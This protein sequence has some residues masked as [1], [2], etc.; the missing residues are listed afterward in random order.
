MSQSTSVAFVVGSGRSGTTAL[1]Q[2]LCADLDVSFISS[3][4]GS[5]PRLAVP[6]A[7]A[8]RVTDRRGFGPSNESVELLDRFGLGH[9][10]VRR[11][12]RALN[13]SDVDPRSGEQFVKLLDRI[14]RASSANGMLIKNTGAT[15][16]VSAMAAAAPEARFVHIVRDGRAVA[17]SLTRVGF[18]ADLPLWW[19]AGRTARDLEAEYGSIPLVAAEHWARQVGSA[20]SSLD[21]L[22]AERWLEV[23]YEDLVSEPGA[24][25]SRVHEFLGTDVFPF[26]TDAGFSTSAISGGSL[27]KWRD[28]L[29][30]AEV[31]T[32]EEKYSDL[33]SGAI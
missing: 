33:L 8:G 20:R 26:A 4:G 19:S 24:T 5:Y 27:A 9:S 22:P 15:A 3:I 2:R 10:A 11:V 30:E 21:L 28:Q 12:G 25:L 18:F 7:L 17:A 16:R 32:I 29:T 13:A 6:A 23:R 31:S 14:S 1:Y